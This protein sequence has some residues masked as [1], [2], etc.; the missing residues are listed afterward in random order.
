[1][2]CSGI[3]PDF[4]LCNGIEERLYL[5]R[6]PPRLPT[7]PAARHASRPGRLAARLGCPL[8]GH[9]RGPSPPRPG[10]SSA[11]RPPL[12]SMPPRATV[13]DE[14]GEEGEDKKAGEEK[15]RGEESLGERK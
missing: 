9:R 4:S 14:L 6:G 3:L 15:M 7:A 11:C 8:P 5:S 1:M 10:R 2:S 12:L 13:R